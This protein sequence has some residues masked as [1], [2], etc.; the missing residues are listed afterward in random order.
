MKGNTEE[1]MGRRVQVNAR[2][3]QF[4]SGSKLWQF[5]VW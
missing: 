3:L 1:G 4:T 5:R 2:V